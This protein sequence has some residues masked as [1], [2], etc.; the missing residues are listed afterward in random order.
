MTITQKTILFVS[1]GIIALMTLFPPFYYAA[2]GSSTYI[3][4]GFHFILNRVVFENR[5]ECVVNCFQLL[6]QNISVLVIASLLV[7]ATKDSGK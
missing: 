5:G 3:G 4:S 1:A 2:A 6:T 7:V